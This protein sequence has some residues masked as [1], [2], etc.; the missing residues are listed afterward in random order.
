[1]KNLERT[2]K[3]ARNLTNNLMNTE[4]RLT[5]STKENFNGKVE[6]N[7]P[8]HRS[9]LKT[10]GYVTD[11]K[12]RK[13]PFVYMATQEIHITVPVTEEKNVSYW[14]NKVFA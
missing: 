11:K 1:M 3:I 13:N 4:I 8:N 14:Y 2:I 5:Y 10:C 6:I 9:G 12:G 7:R